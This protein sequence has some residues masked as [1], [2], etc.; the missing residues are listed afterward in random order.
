[1][2]R[3]PDNEDRQW[4]FPVGLMAGGYVSPLPGSSRRRR[5]PLGFAPPKPGKEPA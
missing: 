4:P 5:R 2:A 3:V 1:M